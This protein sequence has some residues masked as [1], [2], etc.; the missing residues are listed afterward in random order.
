MYRSILS[1]SVYPSIRMSQQQISAEI[2]RQI[3]VQLEHFKA[4]ILAQIRAEIAAT[5]RAEMDRGERLRGGQIV[6]AKPTQEM[7]VAVSNEVSAHV[8]QQV[9]ATLNTTVIPAIK[10]L[11]AAVAYNME[12]GQSI[13]NEYRSAVSTAN[14]G[15]GLRSNPGTVSAQM[16]LTGG[17]GGSVPQTRGRIT[18][19]L[20]MCFDE[21]D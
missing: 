18:Q 5:V 9:N 17:R 3:A 13:I 19:H 10:Q 20:S 15:A 8:M 7:V 11:S 16:R 6:A 14:G 2:S 12:D 1:T 21:E 4:G